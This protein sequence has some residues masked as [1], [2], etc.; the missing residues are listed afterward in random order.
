MLAW[1]D[2]QTALPSTVEVGLKPPVNQPQLMLLALSRSPILWPLICSV[3]G[4]IAPDASQSSCAGGRLAIS[5][6]LAT[7]LLGADVLSPWVWPAM[8]LS[9][10]GMDGPNVEAKL[11][12]LMAKRCA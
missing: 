10:C 4:L 12:S 1:L 2:P 6:P 7:A 3:V 8:R 9:A 11:L 5:V